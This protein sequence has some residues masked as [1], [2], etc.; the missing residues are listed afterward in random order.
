MKTEGR[1]SQTVRRQGQEVF[2]L[3]A[4]SDRHPIASGCV[5]SWMGL[6]S[7]SWLVKVTFVRLVRE[8]VVARGG[9]AR[10]AD[11][12]SAPD[13]TATAF[14]QMID[15]EADQRRTG[16]QRE[17]EPDVLLPIAVTLANDI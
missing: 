10:G 16:I 9:G 17:V 2:L 11:R 8:L 5:A 12:G 13:N 3:S 14:P 7:Q 4:R 1:C 6:L 15:V